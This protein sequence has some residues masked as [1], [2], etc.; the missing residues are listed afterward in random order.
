MQCSTR[1]DDP[2]SCGAIETILGGIWSEILRTDAVRRGDTFPGLGG[3]AADAR[4]VS[5]RLRQLLGVGVSERLL[6]SAATLSQIAASL[7]ARQRQML[8]HMPSALR[9]DS[10]PLSTSQERMYFLTRID[11]SDRAYLTQLAY[12]LHGALH[13]TALQQ[14]FD[15]LVERH[16]ILRTRFELLD[17]RAYQRVDPPHSFDLSVTDLRGAADIDSEVQSALDAEA[18]TPIDLLRGSPIRA[19]ILRIGEDDSVLAIAVHHIVFDGASVRI[20]Q[21]DLSAFYRAAVNGEP[22]C[23]PPLPVQYADYCVWERHWSSAESM[24]EH[25]DYWS[26]TL[27]GVPA[28]L[29]LPTDYPRP[30]L[31]RFAAGFVPI[32]LSQVTSSLKHLCQQCRTTLFTAIVSGWAIVLSRLSGKE[33]IVIGA[34]TLNRPRPE[35]QEVIGLFANSIALRLN[36]AG[37]PTLE[38]LLEQTHQVVLDAQEHAGLPFERVVEVVKPIRTLAYTPLFQVMCRWQSKLERDWDLHLEGLK[39]LEFAAPTTAGRFDLSLRLAERDG[40]IVG[41]L[42]Y[43]KALFSDASARRHA[44]YLNRVLAQM[45][46]HSQ[47]RVRQKATSP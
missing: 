25:V 43:A 18:H 23:L 27:A 40:T 19:R 6:L 22:D 2:A 45:A 29:E 15:R 42:V 4:Q 36:L 20:L 1:L 11:G 35:L 28:L 24:A 41:G 31:Q 38:Q 10:L 33:D 9:S 12:R 30:P 26:E 21:R 34:P 47:M 39:N 8:A 13:E 14:A 3:T 37:D 44:Q 5:Q 32:E 7:R 16:E 46:H 17:G